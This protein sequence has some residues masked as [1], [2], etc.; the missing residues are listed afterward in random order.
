M[1]AGPARPDAPVPAAV[2]ELAGGGDVRTVWENEGGGVVFEVT[3]RGRRRFV[4][5]SPAGSGTGLA[6][7]AARLSGA[8]AFARVPELLDH[9]SD[10]VGSLMVTS[11]LPGQTAV[12]ARWKADPEAL[13]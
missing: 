1:S 8:V 12:A 13:S 6:A 2:L 10:Q 5:W 11:A 3:D 4:K 7:E 9:S